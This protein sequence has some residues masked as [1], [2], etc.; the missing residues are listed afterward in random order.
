M[1]ALTIVFDLAFFAWL[2]FGGVFVWTK[3]EGD[4]DGYN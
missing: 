4:D 3:Q 2:V 1:K